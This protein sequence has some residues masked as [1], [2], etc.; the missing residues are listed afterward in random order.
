VLT[1]V[2]DALE[3]IAR[4]AGVTA[5]V[6]ARRL[7]PE[8][9]ELGIGSDHPVAIASLYKLPLAIAW[10]ELVEDDDLDPRQR[11]VLDPKSRTIGPTGV[12][13]LLDEVTITLRDAVRMMLVVSDNACADTVLSIVG[14]DRLT[15]WLRGAGLRRTRVRH[16]SGESIGIVQ[17][18]T[19]SPDPRLAERALADIDHEIETGEYDPAT[20]SSSTAAELCA[21]L[22]RLWSGDS[23]G[24]E[25]VRTALAQQAW[26][27]RIGSGFPHDDV[28]VHGKTGTLGRL[29]HE[30]AVVAYPGEYP[31]AVAVLTRAARAERHLPRVDAAIGAL[32]RTAVTPLRRMDERSG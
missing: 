2:P 11:L 32:A 21:L 12:A 25:L 30:A 5:W 19:G 1:S 15:A 10:A 22:D 23:E 29:R 7:G 8:P 20:A 24:H 18:E 28:A 16:G 4:D 17:R 6:H 27:H 9:D 13:I 26:R 14:R 31:I 3:Q